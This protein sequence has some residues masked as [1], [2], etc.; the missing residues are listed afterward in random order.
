[1]DPVA[2][3]LGTKPKKGEKC[4]S[5]GCPLDKYPE[6][7]V[8]ECGAHAMGYGE[9]VKDRKKVAPHGMGYYDEYGGL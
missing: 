7:D 8:G 6:H 4:M 5:C 2:N 9:V 3:I 1:M